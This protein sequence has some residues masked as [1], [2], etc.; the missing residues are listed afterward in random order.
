MQSDMTQPTPADVKALRKHLG[1]S[2]DEFGA[3]VHC[4]RRAVQEWE[5]GRRDMSPAVWELY[6][7]KAGIKPL[8]LV[9]RRR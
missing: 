5:A 9:E 7:L 6:L 8:V 1:M 4:S 2:T 3:L